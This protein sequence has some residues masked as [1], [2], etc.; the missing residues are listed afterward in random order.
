[1]FARLR[2]PALPLTL[3]GSAS[4]LALPLIGALL[5]FGL[6][7]LV[8]GLILTAPALILMIA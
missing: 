2:L 7:W 1:M 3:I 4:L 8:L 6:P 5:W